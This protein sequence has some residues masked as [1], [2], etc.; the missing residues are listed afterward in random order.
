MGGLPKAYWSDV[1][2]VLRGRLLIRRG[3]LNVET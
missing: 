2:K 1:E 3:M